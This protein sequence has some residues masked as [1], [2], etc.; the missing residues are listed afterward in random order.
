MCKQGTILL[1]SVKPEG[2]GEMS[3]YNWSL[4][5]K[6]KAGDILGQC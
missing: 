6:I 1:L 5:A 3:A 4:G 2:K